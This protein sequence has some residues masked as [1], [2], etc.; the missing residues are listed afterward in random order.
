MVDLLQWAILYR[1]AMIVIE[2]GGVTELLH[3]VE[4]YSVSM[5]TSKVVLKPQIQD[6]KEKL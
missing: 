5:E 6:I 2:K 4:F 1:Q 3:V